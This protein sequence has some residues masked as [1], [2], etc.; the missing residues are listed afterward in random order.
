MY[1]CMYAQHHVIFATDLVLHWDAVEV[2]SDSEKTKT[3]EVLEEENAELKAGLQGRNA[4]RDNVR[5]L[6]R[7]HVLQ[8]AV[9]RQD[10]EHEDADTVEVLDRTLCFFEEVFEAY[11]L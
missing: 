5:R 6:R 8:H 3:V 1:D 10:P 4:L 9:A 11:G 7:A 2:S